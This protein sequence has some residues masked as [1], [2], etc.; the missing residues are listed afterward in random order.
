VFR[1][2]RGF[3][4]NTSTLTN[5]FLAHPALEDVA[6][7]PMMI[8]R[9][10]SEADLPSGVLPK[11]RR[12]TC[13]SF[14]AAALL[15]QPSSRPLETLEGVDLYD[16]IKADDYFSWD[17]DGDEDNGNDEQPS[18]WKALFLERLERHSSVKRISINCARD[19]FDPKEI[20]ALAVVAPQL[21]YLDIF[22][23]NNSSK[24]VHISYIDKLSSDSFLRSRNHGST[25]TSP[26]PTFKSS[27]PDI[28]C[29][30]E[31]TRN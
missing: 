15:K 30:S 7:A 16:M 13:S 25:Y 9:A 4:C 31:N 14:W 23:D 19:N 8:G 5:F 12:L 29:I 22:T 21:K 2:H 28:F 11:L 27:K 6:L 1:L 26:S 17:E 10:W 20:Q 3:N 18:P 24:Q